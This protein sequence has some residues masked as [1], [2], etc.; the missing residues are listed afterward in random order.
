LVNSTLLSGIKNVALDTNLFIYVFEQSPEF[1]EK[2][3][4]IL[5]QVENGIYSA[6]A[7]AISL[8]EILVK[9]IR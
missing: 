6:V 1:G 8:T 2:A 7:S 3:K 5:E 4:A 9:P